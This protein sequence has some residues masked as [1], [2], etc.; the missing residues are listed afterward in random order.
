LRLETI[1]NAVKKN[2]AI[3]I[4]ARYGA[5][6]LSR[7][8]PLGVA[9]GPASWSKP[10]G[11]TDRSA[12]SW[13]LELGTTS[14]ERPRPRQQFFGLCHPHKRRRRR[15]LWLT[16]QIMTSFRYVPCVPYVACVACAAVDGNPVLA[17]TSQW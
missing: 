14:Y 16:Y 7:L 9:D 6:W 17:V 1:I 8:E 4:A 2:A 5:L 12:P 11:A 10:N 13:N 15:R 3:N